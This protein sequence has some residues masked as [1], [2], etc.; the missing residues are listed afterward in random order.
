MIYCMKFKNLLGLVVILSCKASLC[1][2]VKEGYI[3]QS[4]SSHEK[5]D[6]VRYRDVIKRTMNTKPET[7]GYRIR[8]GSTS[9]EEGIR[10]SSTSDKEYDVRY[11]DVIERTMSTK[12]ETIGRIRSCHEK[13]GVLD[14]DRKGSLHNEK[15]GFPDEPAP[16]PDSLEGDGYSSNISQWSKTFFEMVKNACSCCLCK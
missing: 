2:S 9:D 3:G 8:Q 4:G 11:R 5:C 12:P 10:Q 13:K 16:E 1:A 6:E 14:D 7:I 15:T